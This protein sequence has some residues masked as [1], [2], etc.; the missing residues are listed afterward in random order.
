MTITSF[1]TGKWR[2]GAHFGRSD[3][4]GGPVGGPLGI[5]NDPGR[6]GGTWMIVG[7]RV[8]AFPAVYPT[9]ADDSVAVGLPSG[10]A[11]NRRVGS[12]WCEIWGYGRSVG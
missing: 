1:A 3:S 10:L 11:S 5:E 7:G 12:C 4:P 8:V 2:S 6:L 9:R